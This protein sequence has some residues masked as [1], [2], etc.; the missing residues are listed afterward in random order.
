[1]GISSD[2]PKTI[3]RES[4]YNCRLL[5][6]QR[7]GKEEEICSL[8]P[9]I[10]AQ[11]EGNP[12]FLQAYLYVSHAHEG[13]FRKGTGIPYMIHL[14]RT[15]YYVSQMTQDPDEWAAALL[16]DTLE[17][18]MVSLRSLTL[19]FGERVAQLV[20]SESEDKR[21][22]I[23]AEQTWELR[24]KETIQRLS[25]CMGREDKIP[26][27]HIALGDKLA[28]LFSLS[29][30]YREVKDRVWKKFNQSDKNKHGWY[31]GEMGRLFERFFAGRPEMEMVENYWKYYQEVFGKYEV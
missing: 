5:Q 21:E 22:G 11:L 2:C 24:K 10:Q 23:P 13:Q 12:A 29:V 18:T 8:C 26:T 3:E 17:D 7:S 16:H 9:D 4:L 15:W 19:N 30:E 6:A 25:E 1:M 20:L 14:I 31:Y 27:M 28:N